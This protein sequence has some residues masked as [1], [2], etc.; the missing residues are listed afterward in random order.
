MV[1]APALGNVVKQAGQIQDLRLFLVLHHAAAFRE[2][3]IE[4][5]KR[6]APQIADDE[7]SV[8][9]DRISVEQVILHAAD[10]SAEGGNIQAEHTIKIHASQFVGDAFGRAQGYCVHAGNCD[11]G[12]KAQAKTTLDRNSLAV[13]EDAG[14]EFTID[15]DAMEM[16]VKDTTVRI[17]MPEGRRKALIDGIW[18]STTL[19]V[20][21]ADKVKATTARLPY[22]TV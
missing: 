20:A 3:V 17:E 19:L 13:A 8:L 18:D 4:A 21:N 10:D 11:I 6:K 5:A 9:V 2:F 12:C 7:Q 14:A 1:A 22:M 15:L 16:K